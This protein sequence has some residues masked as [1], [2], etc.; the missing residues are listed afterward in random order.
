MSI[1]IDHLHGRGVSLLHACERVPR[2][3]AEQLAPLAPFAVAHA[4][5]GTR[6]G[7][8]RQQEHADAG[9]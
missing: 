5:R 6:A 1:N 9:A 3:Y 2:G 7:G 4:T 8:A